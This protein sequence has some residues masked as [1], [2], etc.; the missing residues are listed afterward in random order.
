MI[1]GIISS[2]ILCVCLFKVGFIINKFEIWKRVISKKAWLQL[3]EDYLNRQ[4]QEINELKHKHAELEKRLETLKAEKEKI[5]SRPA[6]KCVVERGCIVKIALDANNDEH[7]KLLKMTRQQ[8][9]ETMLKEY[10]E[11]VAYVDVEKSLNRVLVRCKTAEA[12]KSLVEH[13]ELLVGFSKSLLEGEQEDEY[14]GKIDSS[15][16]KK[17]EKK[18]KKANIKTENST[19]QSTIKKV[20]NLILKSFHL[21]ILIQ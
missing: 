18:E 8:F 1:F 15:R 3:K 7:F 14:F 6:P 11:H 13:A 20:V 19:K 10:L 12:A 5:N 4:K 2:K 16:N 21:K 17:A 9:K